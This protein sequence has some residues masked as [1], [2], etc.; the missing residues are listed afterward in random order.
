MGPRYLSSDPYA[1]GPA[2]TWP[3]GY[4]TRQYDHPPR[5]HLVDEAKRVPFTPNLLLHHWLASYVNINW[6]L[7]IEGGDSMMQPKTEFHRLP[8]FR[9]CKSY[10]PRLERVVHCLFLAIE[11]Y[12]V[13]RSDVG[14]NSLWIY[15]QTDRE[16]VEGGYCPFFIWWLSIKTTYSAFTYNRVERCIVLKHGGGLRLVRAGAT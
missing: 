14:D 16:K 6:A 11:N 7:G 1:A 4:N 13:S 2:L 15:L 10:S 8:L 9:L 3:V 12:S 5:L